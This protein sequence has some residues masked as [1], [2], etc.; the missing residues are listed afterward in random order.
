MGNIV[1]ILLRIFP[2]LFFVFLEIIA[3]YI[4]FK[5][6]EYYSAGIV[7]K[8][9]YFIGS[10]YDKIANTKN[11]FNLRSINDSLAKENAKLLQ[12]IYNLPIKNEFQNFDSLTNKGIIN[13][14]SLAEARVVSNTISNTRNYLIINKGRAQG[15]EIDMGVIGPKGPVG[16]VV[17][18][19]ENYACVMSFLNKDANIS[20]RVRSTKQIGVLKWQG[21]DI[22][23]ASLEDI[24]KHVKLKKGEIIETSG[25]STFYP[26]GIVV[27]KVLNQVEDN[28][29]N[30]AEINVLLNTDFSKLEY[31]YVIKNNQ[32][33]ELKNMEQYIDTTI[34][35]SK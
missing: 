15:I 33:K 11:Y 1:K 31:V 23:I 24:P 25:F 34:Q 16:V 32:Y 7:N 29:S 22:R 35:T 28:E 14:Y 5:N 30:F 8:S 27:G 4:L 12:D 2:F 13:Q 17:Q 3:S 20:V 9:N 21:P 26:E 10:F 18:V 19:S 6:N